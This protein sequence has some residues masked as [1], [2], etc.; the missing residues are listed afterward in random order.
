MSC[1]C[2]RLLVPF[3]SGAQLVGSLERR[4]NISRVIKHDTVV[5]VRHLGV[6]S[7]MAG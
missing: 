6:S 2:P 4:Y 7:V 5:S 3:F 1:S